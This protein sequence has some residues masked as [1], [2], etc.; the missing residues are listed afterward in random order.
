MRSLWNFPGLPWTTGSIQLKQTCSN[1]EQNRISQPL[2]G[3]LLRPQTAMQ[4]VAPSRFLDGGVAQSAE[5]GEWCCSW[6]QPGRRAGVVFAVFL[7]FVS[8]TGLYIF[9]EF[10]KTWG[11]GEGQGS[12]NKFRCAQTQQNSLYETNIP[13]IETKKNTVPIWSMLCVPLDRSS[14]CT[15]KNWNLKHHRTWICLKMVIPPQMV[16]FIGNSWFFDLIQHSNT[17]ICTLMIFDSYDQHVAWSFFSGTHYVRTADGFPMMGWPPI[18]SHLAKDVR[19]HRGEE[20]GCFRRHHGQG[21]EPCAACYFLGYIIQYVI[22]CGQ[23]TIPWCFLACW[24]KNW[25]IHS[26]LNLLLP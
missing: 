5:S 4:I 12:N 23:A 9:G 10:H 8:G 18:L 22:S 2:N 16:V 24:P 7:L 15:K 20:T 13:C 1:L 17:W 21:P 3:D 25:L 14:S 11:R 6:S 19:H 26:E